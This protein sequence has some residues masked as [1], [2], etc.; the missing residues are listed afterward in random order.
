MDES[1]KLYK[2]EVLTNVKTVEGV[3]SS[4][5]VTE[6]ADSEAM[7]GLLGAECKISRNLVIEALSRGA[8][9]QKVHNMTGE[10]DV[11]AEISLI[12]FTGK[13]NEH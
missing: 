3:T 7:F 4:R 10:I 11:T 5:V 1:M 2:I 12:L 6:T 8:V 13:T 9:L